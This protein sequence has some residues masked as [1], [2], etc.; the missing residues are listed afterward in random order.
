MFIIGHVRACRRIHEQNEVFV[1]KSSKYLTAPDP[2]ETGWPKGVPYII[3]NEACERFSYYGM[4]AILQVHMTTLFAATIVGE[5]TKEQLNSAELH[6]QEVVHLFAAGAY[7]FPMIGAIVADR[8]LGKYWT[9]MLLSIVYCLGHFVLALAE[10]TLGGMYLGLGLIALGTGGIKPCVSAHVGDQFGKGNWNLVPKV[11]QLFYFAINFGSFFATLLIPFLNARFGSAVAFGVPGILMLLATIAFW[12]G[13]HVFVHVPPSPGGKLG[14]LDAISSSLLFAG[15]IGLPLFFTEMLSPLAFWMILILCAVSGFGLFSYRQKLE[16]DDGFLAIT[17]NAVS[18]LFDGRAAAA[19]QRAASEA[20]DSISRSWLFAG[21]AE[22]FGPEKAE[23]PRAVLRILSIFVFVSVFWALFDQHMSSWIRQAQRMDLNLPLLGEVLPSQIQSLN[24]LMVMILI[25]FTNFM[26]YPWLEKMGIAM[27]PL[28][29]MTIGMLM[30][31]VAFAVVALIQGWIDT[32]D[33]N[34]V[35]VVWQ[36]I[37]YL[38]MT[39]AEVMV[40][41]TGLEFA[42]TQ[43]PKAMKSTIMGFW[44]L[45][46]ALGNKFV[47]VMS[48]FENL[49]LVNFFWL[50]T[51]LMAAAGLLFG[52]FSLF[53]RYKDY[54]QDEAAEAA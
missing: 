23:G 28:R 21:A 5:A 51:G 25:P 29:R 44:L 17:T 41:I 30:A 32:S 12:M 6:A 7:A 2:N 3:G 37:P 45:S 8:L 14:L 54:T 47:A 35:T 40:S 9:I 26:M 19:R 50:F 49:E 27:T 46:V 34:S 20:K 24:P 36:V 15:F 4:R 18:S 53:Y 10:N 22:K 1:A 52:L 13:R 38:I 31:S 48:T 43:A 33:A 16:Q 39:L 11:F 42:Y